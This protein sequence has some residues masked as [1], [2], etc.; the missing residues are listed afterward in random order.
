MQARCIKDLFITGSSGVALYR[1]LTL[2]KIYSY[3]ER[4]NYDGDLYYE[5][6]NDVA[7]KH[8]LSVAYFSRHLTDCNP[9]GLQ[10]TINQK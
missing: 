10:F 5:L 4:M 6:T 2:G 9:S 7:N 3:V 8:T 1:A